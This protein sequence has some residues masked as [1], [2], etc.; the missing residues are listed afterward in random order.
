MNR[1]IALMII[2]CVV[3]LLTAGVYAFRIQKLR[4]EIIGL[5]EKVPVLTAK[6]DL[7]TGHVLNQEDL[8]VDFRT[9]SQASK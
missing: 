6:Q 2:S 8:T 7:S 5:T 3:G 1:K 4:D 9:R